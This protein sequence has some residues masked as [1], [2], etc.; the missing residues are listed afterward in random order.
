MNHWA[1]LLSNGLAIPMILLSVTVCILWYRSA[2]AAIVK[3]E[4]FNAQDWFIVGVFVG[5]T[6]ATI[7]NAYWLLPWSLSFLGSEL[8]PMFMSDGIFSNIFF[9]QGLGIFAGY[10]HVRSALMYRS[11]DDLCANRILFVG[12]ILGV[13]YSGGLLIYSIS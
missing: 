11:K 10:C 9:R 12:A 5:F 13:I 3:K 8:T 2:I 4:K 7:D 1:E 6:C